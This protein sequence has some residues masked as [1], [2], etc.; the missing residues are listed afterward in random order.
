MPGDPE[1]DQLA[2]MTRELGPLGT[3]R[4]ILGR[5]VSH[6]IASTIEMEYE[7]LMRDRP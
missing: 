3:L 6:A 4:Q 1:S 7:K 2:R 5:E